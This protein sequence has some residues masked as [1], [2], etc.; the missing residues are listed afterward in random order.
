MAGGLTGL[1]RQRENPLSSAH[2]RR[3]V[4]G[5]AGRDNEP[6]LFETLPHPEFGLIETLFREIEHDIEGHEEAER[7]S[8]FEFH[9]Q[10]SDLLVARYKDSEPY[11]EIEDYL[12]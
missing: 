7:S 8:I 9:S 6:A 4:S 3:F 11:K 12:S 2:R 5:R 1:Q 10:S